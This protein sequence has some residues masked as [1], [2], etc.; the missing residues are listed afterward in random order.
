MLEKMNFHFKIFQKLK[1]E[2]SNA[3]QINQFLNEK[4]NELNYYLNNK[5]T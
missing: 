5:R 1:M 3:M 2:C 4:I